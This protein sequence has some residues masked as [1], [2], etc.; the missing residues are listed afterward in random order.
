MAARRACV[1]WGTCAL[2]LLAV[3]CSSPV[4]P[5]DDSRGALRQFQARR[6]DDARLQRFLARQTRQGDADP[7]AAQRWDPEHLVLAA[8]YFH[9]DLPIAR[10]RLQLAQAQA[11]SA[12]AAPAFSVSGGVGRAAGALAASPWL[13]GAA[14]DFLVESGGRRQLRA[15]RADALV[16]AARADLQQVAWQV[17]ARVLGAALDVWSAQGRVQDL[18]RQLALQSQR[19]EL[20]ERRL[21]AGEVAQGQLRQEVLARDRYTL[22]LAQAHADMAQARV[23]LALAVGVPS[24]AL[25]AVTLQLEEFAAEPILPPGASDGTLLRQALQERADVRDALAQFTAAQSDLQIELSRRWP[26]VHLGPGYQFDLG[27][28]KYLLSLGA[29][30]PRAPDGPVAEA[31]ARRA[32]I[33]QQLLAL[34]AQVSATV[35][36]TNAG[37]LH[38]A[39]ALATAISLR[40][41]A[42]RRERA[43]DGQWAAGALDRP[44]LLAS[45]IDSIEGA[46]AQRA[47]LERQWRLR[48]ALEDALQA[49]LGSWSAAAPT[50]S[51]GDDLVEHP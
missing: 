25:D 41:Q 36:E 31:L 38:G 14:I 22:D 46:R 28:N 10:S 13:A 34:Q 8:L 5:G 33:A 51:A 18:E 37:W 1:C 29:D 4:P 16:D 26:D 6:L 11:V 2:A 42:R 48:V 32:R 12:R 21:A 27:A 23:R 47:A 40:E 7:A 39:S 20:F 24:P 17:R 15:D 30:W 43:A 50:A 44:A 35:D 49:P 9:P 19:T 3:A 45:R